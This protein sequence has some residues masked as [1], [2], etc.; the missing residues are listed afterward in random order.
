MRRECDID[1]GDGTGDL[2]NA[3]N[4]ESP[5][6]NVETVT[7]VAS[8]D[9]RDGR[10]GTR[11]GTAGTGGPH[12][13]ATTRMT[14]TKAADTKGRETIARRRESDGPAEEDHPG[15]PGGGREGQDV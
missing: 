2:A 6:L 12:T 1:D 9:S 8:G 3:K 14:R 10:A 11:R 4:R 13:H 7:H 15:D 5:G